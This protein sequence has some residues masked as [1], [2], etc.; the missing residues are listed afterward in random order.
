MRKQILALG[1][2]ALLT[3][4]CAETQATRTS[5]EESE[6]SFAKLLARG[7]GLPTDGQA[8]RV[9]YSEVK[10]HP[11][12]K[13]VDVGGDGKVTAAIFDTEEMPSVAKSKLEEASLDLVRDYSDALGISAEELKLDDPGIV[14]TDDGYVAVSFARRVSGREVEGAFLQ[15]IFVKKGDG[16]RMAELSNK[17]FGDFP[18]LRSNAVDAEPEW[19]A[20]VGFTPQIVKR[21][22]ILFPREVGGRIDLVQAVRAEIENPD[23]ED[24]YTVIYDAAT[25]KLL[26][27]VDHKQSA[28]V[29]GEVYDR[30]YFYS[31][32]KVTLPLY[33]ASVNGKT[34]GQ[35]GSTAESGKLRVS[36]SNSYFRIQDGGQTVSFPL[37]VSGSD[38]IARGGQD[39]NVD[40]AALN[41]FVALNRVIGFAGQYIDTRNN[42]Y[43]QR[44]LS[45]RVNSSGTC[46]AY[47]N[48]NITLFAAGGNCGNMA[49]VNDV[50]YHEWGHG[51]DAY[52]GT[53]N[54]IIDS[55]FSEGIGDIVA[56]YLNDDPNMGP[57]FR[58]GS[59]RGI[60]SAKNTARYPEDRGEVHD[61]GT[62][63]SGAFWDMREA[64][65]KRYGAQQGKSKAERIFFRHLL[66]TDY[67]TQSYKGALRVDDDDANPSTKSPNH[68]LITE[69]FA[70][71]GLAT[72]E[73]DCRD[74]V[75]EPTLPS[76]DSSLRLAVA[77][78]DQNGFEL[79][80]AVSGD[81]TV[82]ICLDEIE[83]CVKSGA[84]LDLVFSTKK[85][86]VNIYKTPSRVSVAAGRTFTLL[87]KD[88]SGKVTGYQ[89]MRIEKQ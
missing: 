1:F 41:A 17:S 24:K 49:L 19:A 72:E 87:A 36:L 61:E 20:V 4:A 37:D 78:D 67:Y 88:R 47:Y 59:E 85:S 51:L 52:T 32:R 69:A 66:I 39:G 16:F 46:N 27:A 26:Q 64:L 54:G 18:G 68:C 45:V 86:D 43:F 71:H 74:Q 62:I 30:S 3:N 82:A 73:L 57:G 40:M 77:S 8:E 81:K 84:A 33:G 12:A 21:T 89:Q 63:I 50:I 42:A 58:T 2:I 48:G 14:D 13:K 83:A 25:G 76:Q 9:S 53:R 28:R 5:S 23:K 55:P 75:D 22:E 70:K 34:V 6:S 10:F 60:R 11:S 79:A 7:R 56:S 65:I 15:L 35:D 80:A 31:N 29:M 44:A 38:A